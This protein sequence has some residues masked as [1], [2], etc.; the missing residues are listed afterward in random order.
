MSD[1]VSG[2][3]KSLAPAA[4]YRLLA[5]MPNRFGSKPQVPANQKTGTAPNGVKYFIGKNPI[6]LPAA[7]DGQP[8]QGSAANDLVVCETTLLQ[9]AR[10]FAGPLFLGLSVNPNQSVIYPGALFSDDDVV[11]GVFTPLNMTRKPGSITI[12]VFNLNGSVAQNVENF[13]NRTQVVT[14]INAL[15]S[16]AASAMPNTYLDYFE[17]EFKA[18]RQLSLEM[19]TSMDVNL[20]PIIEIPVQV[21]ADSSGA[22]SVQESLNLAVAALH[23]IYY[24]ISLGGE[25]PASTIDGAAPANALCVT[26]VQ[27]GRTAFLT[28]GSFSSRANASLALSQLISVGL[29]DSLTLAQAQQKLSAE[30]KLALDLG[31]VKFQIVG[32]NVQQAV[33]VSSL[34]SLRDYKSQ[35]EPSVGG[36]GAVPISFTL[37]YAADNAPAQV[38]AFAEYTDRKC[39]RADGLKI[40]LKTIKPTKTVDFGDEELFGSIKVNGIGKTASGS[41]TL[42]S[43]SSSSPVPGKEGQAIS[44]NDE[45]TINLNPATTS[46]TSVKIAVD[47]RDKIVN[48]PEALGAS[49][50][51]KADGFVRYSP[52]SFSVNLSDIRNAPNGKLNKIF[53]VTESDARIEIAM[54]FELFNQ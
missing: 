7:Q 24:T 2:S 1:L 32:G 46:A 12:D 14:A 20:A 53:A 10:S 5:R 16:G 13:N 37:R 47:L 23:Q 3:Q 6:V 30:A 26:D 43:K 25:G 34:Q 39:F 48:D 45:V 9:E 31:M 19:E 54:L 29:D 51:A 18:S 44:V 27:Y 15:L 21:A 49:A 35:I 4:K 33:Q 42:W 8:Q 50:S 40:T 52:G 17:T 38:G 22:V 36:V 41:L 11:R 28:V